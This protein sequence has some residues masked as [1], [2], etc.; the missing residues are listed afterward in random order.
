M[1]NDAFVKPLAGIGKGLLDPVPLD[2]WTVAS[3]EVQFGTLSST[4]C[5]EVNDTTLVNAEFA[6]S[7]YTV[8]ASGWRQRDSEEGQWGLVA[9]S[10]RAGRVCAYEPAGMGQFRGVAEVTIDGARGFYSS[11]VLSLLPTVTS[12]PPGAGGGYVPIDALTVAD[13]QI[14]FGG[15]TS[16]CVSGE[17]D[18][19]GVTYVIHSSKWQ[20]RDHETRAWTDVADTAREGES[21]GYAPAEAGQY[22]VVAEISRDGV[23]QMCAGANFLTKAEE[24]AGVGQAGPGECSVVVGC[25]IP[26]PPGEFVMGSDSPEP[27]DHEMPKTT[28]RI[29]K[30]FQ[31]GKFEVNKEQWEI[32]KGPS[33]YDDPEC[34]VNCPAENMT[35]NEVQEFLMLLSGTCSTGC[36]SGQRRSWGAR[37]NT[38]SAGLARTSWRVP[39]SLRCRTSLR[40][41]RGQLSPPAQPMAT[42]PSNPA[43]GASRRKESYPRDT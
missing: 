30:G 40:Q 38:A 15:L 8:H 32:V 20:G 12:V 33:P 31:M 24:P 3:G 18:L 17:V 36:G 37:P 21:G 41:N 27:E 14:G 22:R 6:Q 11:S 42:V 19:D 34:D 43:R 25:F 1:R 9:G 13:G 23:R 7:N 2:I 39:A 28:V 5:I 26:L 16:Q 35:W 29:S 10:V 4:E